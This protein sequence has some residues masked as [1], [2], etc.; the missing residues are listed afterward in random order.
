MSPQQ[1]RQG[2]QWHPPQPPTF[3]SLLHEAKEVI[4]EFLAFRVLI[5]F[6]ELEAGEREGSVPP[7][8]AGENGDGS[9][10]WGQT[11]PVPQPGITPGPTCLLCQQQDLC[12]PLT[13][14]PDTP[15]AWLWAL[16]VPGVWHGLP[17]DY[18]EPLLQR[19]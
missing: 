18:F 13:E 3:T 1:P 15:S 12:A 14:S 11:L 17:T 16:P 2:W 5:Q 7:A 9:R 6:I 19:R 4:Q 8:H 10:A